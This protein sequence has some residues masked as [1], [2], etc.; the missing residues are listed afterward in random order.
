MEDL[1]S[2]S[3]MELAELHIRNS[4]LPDSPLRA[5]Q[6]QQITSEMMRRLKEREEAAL[7]APPAFYPR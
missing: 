5:A 6:E 2:L 1:K 4:A 3:D 7:I